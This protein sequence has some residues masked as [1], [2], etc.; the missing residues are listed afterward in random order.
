MSEIP[1]LDNMTHDDAQRFWSKVH[2]PY[3]P[4]DCWEWTDAPDSHGYAR[5]WLWGHKV[6]GH[7]IAWALHHGEDPPTG[8]V[9]DHTC[10]NTLCCN[11]DHLEVVTQSENIRRSKVDEPCRAGGH[12]ARY[13]GKNS[14]CSE[15]YRERR[16]RIRQAAA[17]L[18][19]SQTEYK[20]RYGWKRDTLLRVLTTGSA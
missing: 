9:I 11:P 16:E 12:P 17:T 13:R 19:I 20:R 10:R 15:C 7:R 14:A 3:A 8:M 4:L 1:I 5:M 2:K 18:G 6:R